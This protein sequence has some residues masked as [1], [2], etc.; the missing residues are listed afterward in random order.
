MLLG[1]DYGGISET[2]LCEWEYDRE[3]D[4]WHLKTIDHMITEQKPSK[5]ERKRRFWNTV[6]DIVVKIVTEVLVAKINR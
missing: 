6:K 2:V 1:F 5:K 4:T 3:T